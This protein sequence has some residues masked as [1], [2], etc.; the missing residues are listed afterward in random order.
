MYNKTASSQ[1]NIYLIVLA[2]TCESNVGK[3]KGGIIQVEV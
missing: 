1:K 3:K 2:I